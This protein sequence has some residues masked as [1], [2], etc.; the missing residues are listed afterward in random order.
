MFVRFS[1]PGRVCSTIAVQFLLL[2]TCHVFS[3]GHNVQASNDAN[4]DGTLGDTHFPT[5]IADTPLRRLQLAL[6]ALKFQHSALAQ[7]MSAHAFMDQGPSLRASPLLAAAREEE[8]AMSG[9]PSTGFSTVGRASHRLSSQSDGS[10]WYD[11]QE[12]D[13]A[14][15]FL[16]D[17]A[18]EDTQQSKTS[19]TGNA[20]EGDIET[21]SSGTSADLESSSDSDD[22]ESELYEEP[23]ERKPSTSTEV[24]PPSEKGEIAAVRRTV[25]PSPPVGDEGSLFAV[26]KKNVGKVCRNVCAYKAQALTSSLGS[27]SGGVSSLLQRALDLVAETRGRVGIL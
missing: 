10:I 26:L 15:E 9:T 14:E 18:P 3:G 23:P 13:G 12:Y 16:L 22:S 24:T 25:L 7:A 27:R 21:P 2:L 6:E 8:E 11:A 4:E 17:E 1:R 20:P 19:S 5:A